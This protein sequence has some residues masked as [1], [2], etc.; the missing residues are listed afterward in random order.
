MVLTNMTGSQVVMEDRRIKGIVFG[1]DGSYGGIGGA[2]PDS[3]TLQVRFNGSS[4]DLTTLN[5]NFGTIGEFDG[6]SQFG[7]A[8]TVATSGQDG[9]ESGYLSSLSVRREGVIVGMFTNGIRRDVATLKVATFQNPA[10]LTSVGNGYYTA[11]AN[12]GDPVP[13]RALAGGAGSVQGG[14]LDRSNVEIAQEFVNLIEAQNGYQANA[15]TIRVTN[16]MLREL[17]NLIR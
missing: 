2:T 8:S 4:G 15:R 17:A 10:G 6:L 14:T 13:T 3:Q 7:G 12:S 9:Y 1:R 11:S 16:D 5:R